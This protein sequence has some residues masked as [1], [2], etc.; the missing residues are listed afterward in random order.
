MKTPRKDSTMPNAAKR[1]GFNLKIN[2]ETNM[3]QIGVVFTKTVAFIMVV[4]K[5]A[6]TNRMKCSPIRTPRSEIR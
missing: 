3:D 6:E 2:E 4:S 5:T 1:D